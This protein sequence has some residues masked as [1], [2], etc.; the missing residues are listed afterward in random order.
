MILM[1]V[2]LLLLLLHHLILF[3]RLLMV[4]EHLLLQLLGAKLGVPVVLMIYTAVMVVT[5]IGHV[6]ECHLDGRLR[7]V[8]LLAFRGRSHNIALLDRDR[9][10]RALNWLSLLLNCD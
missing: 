4:L 6:L 9:R 8:L 7:H 5:F 2:L 1:M 3:R 10:S